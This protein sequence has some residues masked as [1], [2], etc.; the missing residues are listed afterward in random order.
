MFRII[1]IIA[2]K[3]AIPALSLLTGLIVP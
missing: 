2:K 1:I 3:P